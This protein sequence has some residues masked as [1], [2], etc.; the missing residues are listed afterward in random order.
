MEDT[1]LGGRREPWR[2]A[3]HRLEATTGLNRHDFDVSWQ[4]E[5]PGGGV[6]VSNRIEITT[7]LEAI[8]REDLETTG[9]IGYYR[10]IGALP[11]TR[12]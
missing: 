11:E 5:L 9:A 2:D 12:S 7:D 3:P 1:V 8:L 4:D 6:V 10:E